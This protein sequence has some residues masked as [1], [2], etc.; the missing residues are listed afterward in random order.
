MK[1]DRTQAYSERPGTSPPDNGRRTLPPIVLYDGVCGLC[2]RSVQFVLRH[3]RDK[4][5][6]FASL[7]SPLASQIL[8]RHGRDA[9][10]LDSVY[11]VLHCDPSGTEN[12]GEELLARSDAVL[13]IMQRLGG[14]WGATGS[15]PRCIPRPIRD[16]G[17]GIIARIRYRVFG[18]YD[19]CPLPDA[20]TRGRFLDL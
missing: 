9:S 7:Q 6:R 19:T 13:Y 5:F 11:V 8:D 20:E 16:W 3:D 12:T 1:G 4:T 14:F 15:L 18:K 2:N 10:D 17:Y